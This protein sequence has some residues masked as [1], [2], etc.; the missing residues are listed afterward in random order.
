MTKPGKIIKELSLGELPQF[1]NLIKAEMS[2]IDPCLLL[3]K[4]IPL[5]SEEQTRRHEVKPKITE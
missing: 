5:Y 2:L 1:I 4:Y 3:F